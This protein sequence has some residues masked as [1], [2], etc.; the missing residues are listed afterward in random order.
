MVKEIINGIYSFEVVLPENPLK[1]LNCYVIK[2]SNG[3]RDLLVDCG[4]RRQECIDSLLCGMEELELE[5]KNTD[6][7]FTHLHTDHTGN[8]DILQSLGCRLMMGEIDYKQL[9]KGNIPGSWEARSKRL[10]IPD[11]IMSDIVAHNPAIIY[12][13]KEF[14][15]ALLKGGDVLNYGGREMECILTPGHTPGHMCLYDRKNK[16]MFTGDHILFDIT[17]NI[18]AWMDYPDSL[19][20]YLN[21]LDK[22]ERYDVELALPSHRTVGNKTIYERIE[23]LKIHHAERLK[24]ALIVARTM[25][26]TSAYDMAGYIKWK[27]SAKNWD[28]FP[29]G[30]KWFAVGECM[31]HLEHL[32]ATGSLYAQTDDR[33]VVRYY[34]ISVH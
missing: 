5:F 22:I 25:P 23:E 28:D 19:G 6:V 17:P 34:P 1:W 3:G 33:G 8:A 32:A 30:Q 2:G 31:A 10:G 12:A 27:I 9:L 18:V 14:D 29:P 26:G 13:S 21:S 7:L 15:V 24:E 16:L 11:E 20:L 4:F